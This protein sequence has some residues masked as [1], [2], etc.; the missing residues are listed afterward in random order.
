MQSLGALGE[1]EAARYLQERNFR[2]LHT[3]FRTKIGE[4]DI[5]AQ[6][7]ETVVLIEVK[8]R[9]GDFRGKPYEAVNKRKIEHIKR[10]GY[11]YLQAHNIKNAPLRIDVVSIEYT[12]DLNV[13]KLQHFENITA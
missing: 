3:N 12:A 5:V 7:N 8:S 11:A 6:K 13:K 10:T 1:Q 2:I 4:L 9:I